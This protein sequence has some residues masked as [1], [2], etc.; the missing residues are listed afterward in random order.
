MTTDR[1]AFDVEV[2]AVAR[3]RGF[4]IREHPIRWVNDPVSKVVPWAYLEV[5]RDVVQVRFNLWRGLY[6]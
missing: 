1:W 2:L 3:R 6:D 4:P 5:L